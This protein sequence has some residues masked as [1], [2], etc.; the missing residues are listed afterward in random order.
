MD[1][2][3]RFPEAGLVERIVVE[4]RKMGQMGQDIA[5]DLALDA[6]E[7]TPAVS[8]VLSSLPVHVRLRCG[9]FSG[10]EGGLTRETESALL[11]LWMEDLADRVTLGFTLARDAR[12]KDLW[13]LARRLGVRHLDA[14]RVSAGADAHFRADLL[15]VVADIGRDLEAKA[16]PIDFRPVTRIV[17][18][19]QRS[20]PMA[21]AGED[22]REGGPPCASCWARHLCRNSDILVAEAE[23]EERTPESCAVWAAEAEAALRLYHRLA[24]AD[25]LQVLRVFG[26]PFSLPDELP[27]TP[28]AALGSSKPC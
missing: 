6:G 23:A 25:P 27:T 21:L 1:W 9:E 4:A 5:F 2:N 12:L 8:I 18:R 13:A 10:G 24:H 20:E 16:V 26:E 22:R 19:L 17:R 28:A 7:V 3:G 14:V 11:L 15:A